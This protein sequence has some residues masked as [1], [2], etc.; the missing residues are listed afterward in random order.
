[1]ESCDCVE[2]FYKKDFVTQMLSEKNLLIFKKALNP[3]ETEFEMIL[4]ILFI[5]Q[6]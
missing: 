5:I 2:L 3:F 4:T 1:M 6:I